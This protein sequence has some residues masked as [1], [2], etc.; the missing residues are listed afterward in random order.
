ML[1]A[2]REAWE[3][4][5]YTGHGAALSGKAAEGLEESSGIRSRT[6]AGWDY[7]WHPP[8]GA[9]PRDQLGRGEV[10]VIDEAGMIGSRQLSR[11]VTEAEARGAKIVM[12]GDHEQLQAIGAGAPF[13]AIA[14]RIGH[15]E[16]SEIRRQRVD[17]Q[18]DASAAFATH[19]TADGLAA[20][21]EHGAVQFSESHDE[22]RGAL[23]RDYLA[24]RDQHPDSTRVVRA[25]SSGNHSRRR[26]EP[27]NT[28]K[29]RAGSRSLDLSVS[30]EIV[31]CRR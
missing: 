30:S 2:A 22:A 27:V 1:A 17:W 12:V 25:F 18:R 6:L 7:G 5:G 31:M 11:F 23:V 9:A 21:A 29:R 14:E 13:R 28:S 15:A 19:R 26:P 20:Y 4:Q 8:S 24:D 16:L 3:A 10:F